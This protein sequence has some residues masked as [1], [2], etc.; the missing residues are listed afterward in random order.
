ESRKLSHSAQADP[1]ALRPKLKHESTPKVTAN[2]SQVLSVKLR[3]T[4]CSSALNWEK[5]LNTESHRK[6]RYCL[7][8][9]NS[10]F[11]GV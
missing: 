2:G 5:E 7:N 9:K 4:Q 6:G 10:I 1:A 3:K 11:F 8:E